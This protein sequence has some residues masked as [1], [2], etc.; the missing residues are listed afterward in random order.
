MPLS[1]HYIPAATQVQ[2]LT[3]HLSLLRLRQQDHNCSD[4]E[5]TTNAPFMLLLESHAVFSR[6]SH[7][8]IMQFELRIN[9]KRQP[10]KSAGWKKKKEKHREW[11]PGP[12]PPPL[13]PPR[14]SSRSSSG[15]GC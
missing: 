10:K 11:R 7:I 9:R 3:A 1:L 5:T 2:I 15:A 6:C 12:D 8:D 14:P 13:A 4:C